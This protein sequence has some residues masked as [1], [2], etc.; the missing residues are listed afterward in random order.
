[1]PPNIHSLVAVVFRFWHASESPGVLVKSQLSEIYPRASA[2]AC[3]CCSSRDQLQE[4]LPYIFQSLLFGPQTLRN[5]QVSWLI[6]I[7]TF[8]PHLHHFLIAF[9]IT[10]FQLHLLTG[11][12]SLRLS[13]HCAMNILDSAGISLKPAKCTPTIVSLAC[14]LTMIL[15][16]FF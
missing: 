16:L 9:F 7:T 3:C 5:P 10:A 1:M 2:S 14:F 4:P 11:F 8:W 6:F 12:H 15:K 13:L